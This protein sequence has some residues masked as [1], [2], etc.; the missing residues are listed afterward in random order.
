MD[1]NASDD[2]LVEQTMRGVTAAFQQLTLRYYRR[3]AGFVFKR[4][5]RSDLVEDLVQETFLEAL[6]SL[7]AGR[8]A[9]HFSSWLFGIAHNRCGKWLRRQRPVL[10]DPN[11][12]PEQAAI[13]S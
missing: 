10:F 1:A 8:G 12:A 3:V 6:Q 5:G 9:K 13:P 2:E 4:V 11:E 7:K